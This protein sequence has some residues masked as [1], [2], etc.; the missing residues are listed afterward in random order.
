MTDKSCTTDNCCAPPP[1]DFAR[2]VTIPK[3]ALKPVT[4]DACAS[5]ACGCSGGVP[6]FDGVDVRYKRVL[7]TVITIMQLSASS[8]S[9]PLWIAE[10]RLVETNGVLT[11]ATNT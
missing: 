9:S 6:V 8:C 2:P 4:Q 1:I 5:E 3:T 11:T 7:W 10:S